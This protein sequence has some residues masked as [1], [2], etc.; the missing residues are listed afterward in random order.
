MITLV[1]APLHTI[2]NLSYGCTNAHMHPLHKST[3]LPPREKSLYETLMN[4]VKFMKKSPPGPHSD[5]AYQSV[6]KLLLHNSQPEI[7]SMIQQ[8]ER[9]ALVWRLFN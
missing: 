5:Y 1:T 9:L 8:E 6:C 4:H 7:L 2:I 3:F